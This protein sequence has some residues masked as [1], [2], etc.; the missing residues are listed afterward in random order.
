MSAT[1]RRLGLLA[2]VLCVIALVPISSQPA[3]SAIS[4][5]I[6]VVNSQEAAERML[7]QLQN[8]ENFVALAIG[9]SADPSAPNGGLVGPVPVSDLRPEI[10]TAL[11][12]LRVGELSGIVRLPTGFGILKVVRTPDAS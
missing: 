5:R 1:H 4:F 12:V 3:V 7:A 11:A 8:G 6:I 10:R 2:A 9:S